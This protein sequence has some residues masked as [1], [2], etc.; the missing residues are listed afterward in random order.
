MRNRNQC[1]YWKN[2]AVSCH[3][4]F[5]SETMFHIRP[6]L[7]LNEAFPDYGGKDFGYITDCKKTGNEQYTN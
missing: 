7:C 2:T 6:K 1:S 3:T 5:T 4:T